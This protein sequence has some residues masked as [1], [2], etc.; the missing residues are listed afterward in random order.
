MGTVRTGS[1]ARVVVAGAGMARWSAGRV[2]FLGDAAHPMTPNLGQ[3]GCQAIEDAIVLDACLAANPTS[4]GQALAAYQVKR[5]A[6]ANRVVVESR[7]LGA[8]A[9]WKHPLACTLR[10]VLMRVTPVGTVA[11][12]LQRSLR[13]EV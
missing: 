13:F 11:K 4:L 1:V 8:I 2:V 9:Q 3:G 5:V 6:R 12:R 10:E 7:R